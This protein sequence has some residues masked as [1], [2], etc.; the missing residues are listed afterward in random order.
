MLNEEGEV[1]YLQLELQVSDDVEKIPI[2]RPNVIPR[3]PGLNNSPPTL[4]NNAV[5]V[6]RLQKG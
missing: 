5:D 3:G 1:S 4:D 2:T 6:Q